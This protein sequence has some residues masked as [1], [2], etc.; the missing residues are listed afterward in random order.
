MGFVITQLFAT[1]IDEEENGKPFTWEIID[2]KS[3]NID[4]IFA[5]DQDGKIL[6]TNSNLH[7]KVTSLALYCCLMPYIVTLIVCFS[8]IYSNS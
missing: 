8:T 6:L 1:D 7:K 2:Q 3:L 4:Q 5:I